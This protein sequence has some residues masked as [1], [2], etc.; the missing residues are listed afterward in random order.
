[1]T[2]LF[3]GVEKKFKTDR[4][5]PPKTISFQLKPVKVAIK[6]GVKR[7]ASAGKDEV[8]AAAVLGSH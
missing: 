5:E 4:H 1:M 7:T 6:I 3:V 8:E 2:W